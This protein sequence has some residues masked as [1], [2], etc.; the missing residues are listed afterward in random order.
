MNV[1]FIGHRPNGRPQE[2]TNDGEA[3][4][5]V[6]LYAAQ[7]D[8][9]PGRDVFQGTGGSIYFLS[10]QDVSLGSETLSIEV[11]DRTTGRVIDR[12]QLSYGQDYTI[13]HV[14][15]VITLAQPLNSAGGNGVVVTNPG[16]QYE[17][18]LVAQYEFT[19]GFGKR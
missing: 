7:P 5:A 19:P 1:R 10:Q 11:R 16:G 18:H 9:L 4:V 2:Q 6:S 15:G 12:R 8:N 17:Y 13:N 3:R 14:Q